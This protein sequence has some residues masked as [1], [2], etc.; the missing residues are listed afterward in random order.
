VQ[1][2]PATLTSFE[3]SLEVDR[4]ITAVSIGEPIHVPRGRLGVRAAR[5]RDAA[6]DEPHGNC[7]MGGVDAAPTIVALRPG[8]VRCAADGPSATRPP[9]FARRTAGGGQSVRAD[10]R[11]QAVDKLGRAADKH[12]PN[13]WPSPSAPASLPLNETGAQAAR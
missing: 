12:G 8:F 9:P 11:G 4:L 1:R 10:K 3:I 7:C 2:V 5:V 6:D 13:P